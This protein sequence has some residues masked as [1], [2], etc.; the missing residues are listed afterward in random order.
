[1]PAA[2]EERSELKQSMVFDEHFII[3][4]NQAT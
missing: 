2:G 4:R 3:T 1:M